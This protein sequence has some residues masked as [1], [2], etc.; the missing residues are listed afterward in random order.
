MIQL[1]RG[2]DLWWDEA[3][4]GGVRLKKEREKRKT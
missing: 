1:R 3:V 2:R 4:F